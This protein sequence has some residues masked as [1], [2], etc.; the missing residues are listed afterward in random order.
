MGPTISTT[1]QTPNQTHQVYNSYNSHSKNHKKETIFIIDWDDTLMCTYFISLKTHG[2]SEEE[3]KIVYDLGKV[4]SIFL[5]ECNKYGKVIIMTNS[6]EEWLKKT[7]EKYLK[8]KKNIFENIKII[9][10]RD[11][12]LKKNI[13]R[14]KWKELALDEL[15]KRYGD[16]IQN[17]IC[18]SDSESDIEVFKNLSENTLESIA[19]NMKKEKFNKGDVI[20]QEGTYGN[21]FYLISKGKVTITKEGKPIRVLDQGECLGEK[22]LLSNDSLRTASAI[23]EDKVICYVIYKKEFD[24]ILSDSNTREYLLKKLAFQNT[25]I[26]LSDLFYI[27]FLGKGKFGSV[28][29]VHNKQNF[30]AIKAIS[31]KMVEREKMLWK[32]FVN[33]R[34]IMISL[35]HPFIVKMVKSL[36]NT[37][38]CF[39]LMEFVNELNLDDHLTKKRTKRNIYETQ[40][41]I[42]SILLMLDYLQ[43]KYIAHRDI[44]PSNIMI[45]SNGYLKMIDFGTAKVLKDYTSTIIGTPHY[46]APEILQGKGYSL[47]CDF[48]SLGICMFEIFYG[49]YPFGNNANEVIDIYKE[50][51]KKTLVFPS[52]NNKFA[53]VN[54]FIRE[55]LAKK[56]NER[57]CNVSK[58]K[59]KPFFEGFEFNR[60]NDFQLE[61]PYKPVKND[62]SKFF[63]ETTSYENMV[64]DDKESNLPSH[65]KKKKIEDDENSD[66]D[67]NWIEVF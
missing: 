40:F 36:R 17:I 24:M 31:I 7:N 30:Y 1:N 51:L 29:L 15:L 44:K 2:L 52:E 39:I 66:Y 32:Y 33:E 38:Y 55:L 67:P 43:K 59:Q 16:I 27:K 19:K 26:Q 3:S 48:W 22:S 60:L 61:P 8:I 57:L 62:M 13:D 56:V 58:L 25:D 49:I 42:G 53:N 28:S 21:T 11:K 34:N 4:V 46:I 6:S 12:Y 5:K 63:K 54:S 14:R 10:T 23:A 35:D 50:V 9:S 20:I 37:K 41:Y 65:K 64:K 47:S 18:A 45:D